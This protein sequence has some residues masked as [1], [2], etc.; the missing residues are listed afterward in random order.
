MSR[1]TGNWLRPTIQRVPPARPDSSRLYTRPLVF[2]NPSFPYPC[3]PWANTYS[4]LFFNWLNWRFEYPETPLICVS[5]TVNHNENHPTS[6]LRLSVLNILVVIR[7]MLTLPYGWHLLMLNTPLFW[8]HVTGFFYSL[9]SV[10]TLTR[11]LSEPWIKNLFIFPGS[12]YLL[13]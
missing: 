13:W 11:H 4:N 5:R 2:P 10:P 12:T 1:C 3:H 6:N 8:S 7:S 9:F